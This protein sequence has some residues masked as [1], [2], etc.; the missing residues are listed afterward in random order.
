MSI[1]YVCL[2]FMG[3]ID[4]D[5]LSIVAIPW[6]GITAPLTGVSPGRVRAA[7]PNLFARRNLVQMSYLFASTPLHNVS[8]LGN[9]VPDSSGIR[10]TVPLISPHASIAYIVYNMYPCGAPSV[11]AVCWFEAENPSPPRATHRAAPRGKALF[12]W[13]RV[14]KVSSVERGPNWQRQNDGEPQSLYDAGGASSCSFLEAT[15]SALPRTQ[16]ALAF[17]H[18][19]NLAHPLGPRPAPSIRFLLLR[20]DTQ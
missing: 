10:V 19:S 4:A 16:V 13:R 5:E 11:Q 2:P 15:A 6:L 3:R 8:K 7:E 18:Q 12:S 17:C 1:K 14:L 9:S 20:P